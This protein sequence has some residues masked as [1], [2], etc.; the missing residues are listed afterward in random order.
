MSQ[1]GPPPRPP[2]GTADRHTMLLVALGVVVVA[3]LGAA[4]FL[5]FGGDDDDGGRAST[6][7]RE[8]SASINVDFQPTQVLSHN[9]GTPA[10]LS[11]EQI[12][13]IMDT[14]GQYLDRAVIEPLRTGEPVGD[15]ASLFDAATAAQLTG[16]SRPALFE[17]GLPTASGDIAATA[18]YVNLDGLADGF[19]TFVLAT[20]ASDLEIVAE[21]DDGELRIH[22]ITELTLVPEG[23]AWKIAGYDVVVDRT[24]PGVKKPRAAATSTGASPQ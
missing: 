17:E 23:P 7:P 19:G 2:A 24:G 3:A 11:P 20:V 8:G 1:P 18:K 6:P 4:A 9:T 13:A 5:F 21:T 10:Q 14:A 12:T 16:L 15:V 22:R